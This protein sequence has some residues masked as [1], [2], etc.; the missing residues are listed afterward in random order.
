MLERK[1][2]NEKGLRFIF[3]VFL[4]LCLYIFFRY[5]H[6]I[7]PWDGDDWNTVMGYMNQRHLAFPE[8][9]W[10]PFSAYLV[11]TLCGYIAGFLI[12]PLTGDYILALVSIT[13]VIRAC[14]ILISIG[15]FYYLLRKF[16]CNDL[17]ALV[18]ICFFTVAAFLIFKTRGG[19][20]YLYWQYNYCTV[21]CYGVPNYL[22]SALAVY[23][24]VRYIYKPKFDVDI[25]TGFLITGLYF[26]SFSFMPA[27]FL[28]SAVSLCIII[29]TFI[30]CQSVV[31]TLRQCWIQFVTLILFAV[32]LFFEFQR[33]FGTGYFQ[34]PTSIS[35]QLTGSLKFF[36]ATFTKM[37]KLFLLPA[38][39][40][41]LWAFGLFLCSELKH[42]LTEDDKVFCKIGAI[43]VGTF[44]FTA[45]FFVL[46]GTIDFGHLTAN[47]FVRVDTMYVLYFLMI[48]TA[49]FCLT[50][51]LKRYARVVAV[52]ILLIS[53]MSYTIVSPRNYYSSTVGD[54]DQTQHTSNQLIEIMRAVV[55]EVSKR[56]RQGITYTIVHVPYGGYC[57]GWC[58]FP[59]YH[60]NVTNHYCTVE[61]RYEPEIAEMYFE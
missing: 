35:V 45:I 20:E 51:I 17:Y 32:S 12:Y 52:F 16:A 39:A 2:I 29:G 46:F 11:S 1:I 54:Y 61:F 33:T 22:S 59:L 13:A 56:D 23:L 26:L 47:G 15:A 58:N 6:P 18:G 10:G 8:T 21:Y 57:G 3:F 7:G 27:S 14:T 50:Y 9:G 48:A 34:A 44:I 36:L 25:K 24:I 31:M 41:I 19:S 37:N 43:L 28:V 5:V 60:H 38:V 30:R 40:V 4:F 55:Q 53:V 42:A 49:A